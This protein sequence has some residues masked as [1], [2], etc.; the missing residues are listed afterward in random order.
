MKQKG[1]GWLYLYL[2]AGVSDMVMIVEG[3]PEYRYYT[4]PLIMLSL[5]I[6][7]LTTTAVIKNSLLRKSVGAG[8]IFGLAGDVLLLFPSLFLYGLGAFLITLIC[9]TIAFKLTQNH[10]INLRNINFLKTFFYNLPLYIFADAMKYYGNDKPDLRFDMKFVELNDVAQNKGFKIF[11]EAELV[12]GIAAPGAASYTR[13]QVDALTEWVKRPQIGAKG[14]VYVKCNDDG[15]FKSSVDKFYSQEDLK[16]WADKMNAQPGDLILVLSGD[17]NATRKQLS[18]LRLKMGSDLGLRDKNTFKPLWVLDFPLLEWDEDTKRFH[19]M[20]HPFTS[21]KQEDIPLLENDP[22]AVR[23][24]A[25]DLVINGVEIGGGSIRIHDRD[26]QKTMFK[27]LGF[28][29]EEAQAQFGFLMEAFEYG[30]PPH[31]GIAFGFDRLCA[32]FGGSDSIRDYIAFPKNNS[33]RDVMIDS[34]S[35]IADEQLKEL[36]IQLALKK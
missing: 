17:Q 26:T 9:Y 18:E 23:A 21:P 20:H 7:F 30:A 31:G 36:S 22:G 6:Y 13:K 19:A 12:V 4:K 27:H 34:P 3:H 28:S 11:D 15:T 25:Y 2:F 35:A 10:Q 5:A 24:N 14:L 32:I 8:L 1:I 16:A 29:D 33:G